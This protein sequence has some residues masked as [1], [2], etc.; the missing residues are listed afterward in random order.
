[1]LK[2]QF[3]WVFLFCLIANLNSCCDVFYGLFTNGVCCFPF[4][5]LDV[6]SRLAPSMK[7]ASMNYI[8]I[9]SYF[10]YSNIL[11]HF[12]IIIIIIV[13]L[14]I[15]LTCNKLSSSQKNGKSVCSFKCISFS[16][17]KR[18]EVLVSIGSYW[19]FSSFSFSFFW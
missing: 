10:A 13:V 6:I 19:T 5:I 2:I 11:F 14:R 15:L 3:L 4:S 9:Y 12:Q 17:S 8:F 7:D 1:L 18:T 16:L